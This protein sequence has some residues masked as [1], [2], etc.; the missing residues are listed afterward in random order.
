ML[1]NFFRFLKGYVVFSFSGGFAEGFVNSCFNE[2]LDIKKIKIKNG[3]LTAQADIKTYKQLHKIALK[4]GGVVKII[5][6]RGMPFLTYP[7]KN[8][9]G[10]FAGAVFFVFFISFMGGFIWNI[11][12]TGTDRVTD[13]QIMDYLAQNGVKIGR[14]WSSID[15]E[16]LE[17]GV[18]ADFD[19]VSWISINKFGSTAGIEINE[20]VTKPDVIEANIIT[21]VVA[22][23]DGIITHITALGGMPAVKAGEA[24]TKG[25][26]LISGV[27]ESE[28]D[29]QNHFTHAH[30]TA[31]AE[32]EQD[33]MLNISRQQNDKVY[34]DEKI[35]KSFYFFG[36]ELAL[37]FKK[38]KRSSDTVTEISYYLLNDVKLPIAVITKTEHYYEIE[39]KMLTDEELEALAKSELERRADKKLFNC[40]IISQNVELKTDEIGC[41][42]IGSYKYIA[43]IGREIKI[44]IEPED[45][46]IE[47]DIK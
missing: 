4:H 13:A 46:I 30:G 42:I 3:A 8:R 41:M 35:Y 31:L 6:K 18:L 27:Y 24:V 20:A 23:R 5:K 1:V 19:D 10:V 26:L 16:T 28:V 22:D 32:A 11:T 33:I 37:Y 39:K 21:N 29:G 36:I 25:D 12:V 17:F 7:L 34:K 9:W 47:N 15:K 43:D 2:D 14:R 44:E 40:K 45:E 38:D